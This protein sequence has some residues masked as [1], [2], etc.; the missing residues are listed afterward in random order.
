MYLS[1]RVSFGI[2][3]LDEFSA[4]FTKRYDNSLTERE[5]MERGNNRKRERENHATKVWTYYLQRAGR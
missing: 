3:H 1:L 5:T 2:R 4:L